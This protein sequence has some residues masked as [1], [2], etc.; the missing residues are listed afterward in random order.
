MIHGREIGGFKVYGYRDIPRLAPDVV[1]VPAQHL[2]EIV[3]TISEFKPEK[4]LIA[5]LDR[6]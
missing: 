4:A 5:V 6:K 3:N 1:L 2:Q